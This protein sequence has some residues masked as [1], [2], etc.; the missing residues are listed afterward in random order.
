MKRR[1]FV[2]KLGLLGGVAAAAVVGVRAS[3]AQEPKLPDPKPMEKELQEGI[4][5]PKETEKE[6]LD[7]MRRGAA[8]KWWYCQDCHCFLPA[9]TELPHQCYANKYYY[10]Q[11]WTTWPTQDTTSTTT[12]TSSNSSDYTYHYYYFN[13]P[14]KGGK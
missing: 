6:L 2:T 13:S 8:E 9:G 12:S 3:E 4:K 10:N 5:P 11:T 7:R 14:L 1:D